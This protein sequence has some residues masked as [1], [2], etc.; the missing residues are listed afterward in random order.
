[1][2]AKLV[3]LL[4]Q[5]NIKI[6]DQQIQQLINLVNLLNKWNKAYN[7]TSVRDPQEMLVK[8]IL[9]SLVVSPYLQGDRFIDVGTG[10]GLPGLPL[11][12][13]NPSKQFV[14]LDSLGKRISFIRN[15]IRELGLTNVTP[16]LSRVEEYQPED[17]FDGVLSR[18]FASLKDMT[19]WCY[20]LPKE[21]GYFYALKGI[22]Q[23]DEINEL[24]KKYTIQK[25]IEL[26]VPELIGER[27]LIV[28][29]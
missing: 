7:L 20:H 22:Y 21:N 13:I 1:M 26:S 9:D 8:H 28:L 17:K 24:N 19:D 15:A 6:S 5:A 16:V 11:A 2:K 23:E 29:R 14:L 3:S 12:I 18:A 10:P 25:V 27:H 4:A